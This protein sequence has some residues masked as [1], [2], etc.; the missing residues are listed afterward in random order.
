MSYT[1]RWGTSPPTYN[2]T[3]TSLR[4]FRGALAAMKAGTRDARLTILGDSITAGVG[5][6]TIYSQS[7]WRLAMDELADALGVVARRGLVCIKEGGR[8]PDPQWTVGAGWTSGIQNL[9]DN[10]DSTT[11]PA[12]VTTTCDF[13][14]TDEDGNSIQCDSFN[15]YVYAGGSG[16]N[17]QWAIDG[18]SFTAQTVT[19]ASYGTG[20]RIYNVSA[21]SVGTHTLNI[22]PPTT[23]NSCLLLGAEAVNT[24]VRGIRW[25]A[26]GTAG[27]AFPASGTPAGFTGSAIQAIAPDLFICAFIINAFVNQTDPKTT[28]IDRVALL[29]AWSD[30]LTKP[31]D[32]LQMTVPRSGHAVGPPTDATYFA[33][34]DIAADAGN[35]PVLHVDSVFTYAQANASPLS[36]MADTI[37]P[38]VAGHA[39]IGHQLA[40]LLRSI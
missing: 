9:G 6:S 22:K 40:T 21:G 13:T 10:R 11:G 2:L 17:F 14:P 7:F 20:F 18:G 33:A 32:F 5:T 12:G 26:F 8:D 35:F 1:P 25:S 31:A 34:L 38:S 19:T 24:N 37:H 36:L 16:G 39:F 29:K 23:G 27:A 28:V 3:P 4:Y 15:V 30:A